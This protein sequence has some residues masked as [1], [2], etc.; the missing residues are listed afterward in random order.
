MPETK[1]RVLHGIRQCEQLF[2]ALAKRGGTILQIPIESIPRSRKGRMMCHINVQALML[3]AFD[4]FYRGTELMGMFESGV[5]VVDVS[6]R[7]IV[8]TKVR[9]YRVFKHLPRT[10]HDLRVY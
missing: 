10:A 8:L 4:Q 7:T 3:C 6:A 1:R 2:D 5:A 9:L